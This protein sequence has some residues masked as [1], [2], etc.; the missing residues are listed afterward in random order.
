MGK[1]QLAQAAGQVLGVPLI[2][3]VVHER[4][5]VG[6]LL[7]RVDSVSRLAEAQMARGQEDRSRL[8]VARFVRPGPLWWAFNWA[9]ASERAE[10]FI[11]P[12]KRSPQRENWTPSEGGA[13]VLIDEIDKADTSVPNGLLESLGNFGFSV[14]EL[15]R[16]VTP[17]ANAEPPLVI[18]TTNEERELPAAFVRRCFVLQ[19]KF[20]PAGE[21]IESYLTGRALTHYPDG[22]IEQPVVDEVIRQLITDRARAQEQMLPPPGAA[23]FLDILR[24]LQGMHPG[25]AKAQ[26]K[27]LALIKDFALVKNAPEPSTAWRDSGMRS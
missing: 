27:S 8:E 6:E 26:L 3:Q 24:A 25:D 7:Y 9:S 20:P 2:V 16:E 11:R 19:M 17:P 15:D 13:V 12:Y 4:C 23:E 22:Q 10:K 1:S 5:E 21:S 14:P 18:V